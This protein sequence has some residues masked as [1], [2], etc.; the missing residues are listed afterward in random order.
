M[1]EKYLTLEEQFAK[2]LNNEEI[3]RIKD[4]ELRDIRM[5]HWEYRHE[6]FVNERKYSDAEF[7]RLTDID[8]KKEEKE[9]EDY[10]KRKVLLND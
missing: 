1:S 9:L 7:L 10:K 3:S 6:I 8:Y 4:C 2:T 5:K